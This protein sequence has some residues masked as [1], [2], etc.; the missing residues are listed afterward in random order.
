MA[1]YEKG[2]KSRKTNE[3]AMKIK[4]GRFRIDSEHRIVILA[5]K[6]TDG[7]SADQLLNERWI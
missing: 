6:R 1:V 3:T 2:L 4:K 7:K 5:D